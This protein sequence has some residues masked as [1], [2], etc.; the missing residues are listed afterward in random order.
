MS[1][2]EHTVNIKT[3]SRKDLEAAYIRLLKVSHMKTGL[4]RFLE[5]GNRIGETYDPKRNPHH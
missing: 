1:V 4:I 2:I 5:K 3:L